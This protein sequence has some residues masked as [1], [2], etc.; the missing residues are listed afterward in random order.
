MIVE[1]IIVNAED[2]SYLLNIYNFEPIM[3]HI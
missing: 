2:L 3:P 1:N